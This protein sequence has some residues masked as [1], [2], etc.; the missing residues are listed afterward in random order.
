MME[1]VRDNGRLAGAILLA[2]ILLVV[3]I[4]MVMQEFLDTIECHLFE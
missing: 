1:R 3:N 2:V 4:V